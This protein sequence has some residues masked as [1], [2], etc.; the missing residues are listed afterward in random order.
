[1]AMTSPAT[2]D[3]QRPA[4]AASPAP[5]SQSVVIGA[6]PAPDAASPRRKL[7]RRAAIGLAVL[8]VL[9]GTIVWGVNYWT[10]GRFLVATDD[11]YVQADVITISPQVQGYVSQVLV[12]DNAHVRA[13][14]LLATIDDRPFLAALDQAKAAVAEARADIAD[15]EATLDQQASA[16]AEASATVK[17]DEAAE[18]FAEQN[19]QRFGKLASEG[20]G[21]VARAQETQAAI[22]SDKATVTKDEAALTVAQK[23][24]ATLQAELAKAKAAL[25]Q[26]QAAERRAELDLGYTRI[27]APADGVIGE[28]TLRQGA[29]VQPGTALMAVVPL[30]AVYVVANFEETQLAGV[31]EGQKV[32]IAVDAFPGETV[33]GVVNSLAPASGQEFSLLPPDNATGNFTKI[34]QRIPVKITIDAGDPLAGRLRPGMS[35]TPTIDTRSGPPRR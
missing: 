17:V 6:A 14:Q 18:A 21:T 31:H 28:R 22:D 29:F 25:V 1:M 10:T 2:S 20:F 3:L 23:E 13:G 11:A 9:G 19:N 16:I 30:S 32:A 4:P 35:V 24:V 34:V 15:I 5:A 33:H 7:I 8:A 27:T 12:D 26:Q